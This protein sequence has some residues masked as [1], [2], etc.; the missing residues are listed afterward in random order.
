MNSL[1]F[2]RLVRFRNGTP[3]YPPADLT[4]EPDL[5]EKMPE[6]PDKTVLV[7]KLKKAKFHNGR[8][9]TAEDVKY[10]ID[11]YQNFD[12]SVHKSLWS[13]VDKLETPDPQTLR[14]TMK[15]P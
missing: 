3:E 9:V 5:A 14:L 8:D 7:F 6:Q 12:K 1:T 11:R 10:T 2:S 4:M 13:F 15:F